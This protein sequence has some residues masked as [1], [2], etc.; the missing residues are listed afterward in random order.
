M[1]MKLTAMKL[2]GAAL[3]AVALAGCAG[4]SG[5]S[6][7]APSL[8]YRAEQACLQRA[9][10]SSVPGAHVI[11]SEFSQANTLVTIGDNVRGRYRCLSSNDG[12]VADFSLL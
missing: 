6:G 9:R 11:R 5:G 1:N 2:T 8:T 4:G 10:A 7:G 3:A 12:V